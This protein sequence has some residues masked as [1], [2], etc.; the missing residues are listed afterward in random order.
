MGYV[1]STHSWACDWCGHIGETQNEDHKGRPIVP[2]DWKER[3]YRDRCV[4]FCSA[5]CEQ[6][7][8]ANEPAAREAAR[9]ASKE[10]FLRV[11]SA[12]GS[13]K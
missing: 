6:N 11:M 9:Q 12:A 8:L 10:A 4:T 2:D 7:Y 5:G 13:R 1:E 3:E